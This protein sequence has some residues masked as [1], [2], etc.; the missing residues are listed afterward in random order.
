M[1]RSLIKWPALI[2]MGKKVTPEQAMEILIRTDSWWFSGNDHHLEKQLKE[3]AGLYLDK[4]NCE[5]W[6]TAHDLDQVV[7]E[8]HGVLDLEYLTNARIVSSWVGG[9]HGWCDWNG[10]IFC[11]NYNIGKWPSVK[12]VYEEWEK[13]AAAFPYLDLRCQLMNCETSEDDPQPV[14]EFV[15]FGGKVHLVEP[16]ALMLPPA[17]DIAGAALSVFTL[18]SGQREFGTTIEQFKKALALTKAAVA[19]RS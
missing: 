18:S 4:D 19:E 9:P 14:V 3:I 7:K 16:E 11:N 6:R 15:V 8:A 5:D 13:I 17:F 10:N 1:N 2:V 12:E